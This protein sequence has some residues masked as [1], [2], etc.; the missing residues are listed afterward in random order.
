MVIQT[1]TLEGGSTLI[2]DAFANL[3]IRYRINL[4]I[5][6]K[7]EENAYFLDGGFVDFHLAS[8]TTP[9]QVMDVF[10]LVVHSQLMF[11]FSQRM[12]LTSL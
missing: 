7:L 1:L 2:I 10:I 9:V 12:I 3:S 5:S 6:Y 4:V 8:N 11:L